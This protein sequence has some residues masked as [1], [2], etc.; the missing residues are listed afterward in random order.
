MTLLILKIEVLTEK[1]CHSI[2]SG[3]IRST[4]LTGYI[5]LV[6]LCC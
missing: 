2:F 1:F 4:V 5:S 6:E 3:D